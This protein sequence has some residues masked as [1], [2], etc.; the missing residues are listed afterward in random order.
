MADNYRWLNAKAEAQDTDSVFAFYRHLI[1]LRKQEAIIQAGD[2]R[3]LESPSDKVI[4]YERTFDGERLL[5]QCNFSGDVQ[6]ALAS[7]GGKILVSNYDAP[8][9]EQVLRPWEATAYIWRRAC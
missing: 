5:V 4:A 7:T 8:G 1:A 2:V 9:E 3:F 6:P